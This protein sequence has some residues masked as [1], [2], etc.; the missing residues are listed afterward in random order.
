MP[1]HTPD[2]TLIRRTAL[3]CCH[4]VRNV[5]YYRVG[6]V[7]EDGQGRLKYN[8]EFGRTVN[9][10]FLDVAVLEWCKVFVDRDGRHRWTRILRTCADQQAFVAQLLQTL[11]LPADDWNRYRQSVARY[12]DKFV[13]HLDS[14]DVMPIPNMDTALTAAYLFYSHLVRIAPDG[15]LAPPGRVPLPADLPRYYATSADEA[16]V[17]YAS[18]PNP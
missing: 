16:R 14:D 3:L 15:V 5:A 11:G 10:N 17:S 13:A 12:R 7:T 1:Q 4:F 9:G 18:R 6:Y 8:S 2:P